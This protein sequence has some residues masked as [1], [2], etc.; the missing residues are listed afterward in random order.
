MLKSAQKAGGKR[1]KDNS[2][3]HRKPLKSVLKWLKDSK[4]RG[5]LDKY[6][7]V[8]PS[9]TFD[10]E[11]WVKAEAISTWFD[12]SNIDIQKFVDDMRIAL[13]MCGLN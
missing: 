9:Q 8:H 1:L 13:N 6:I 5:L 2:G 7:D 3:Y 10:L 4:N 11:S 12:G